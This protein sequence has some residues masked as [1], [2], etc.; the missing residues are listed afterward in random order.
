MSEP[1]PT[2][3]NKAMACLAQLTE[4]MK[5]ARLEGRRDIESA[6]LYLEIAEL[7]RA[8]LYDEARL[9]FLAGAPRGPQ[10]PDP[11]DLG[12]IDFAAEMR[13]MNTDFSS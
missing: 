12:P 3:R 8:V 6:S 5:T 2:P 9:R 4:R 7:I 11:T 1:L 13:A 10:Q